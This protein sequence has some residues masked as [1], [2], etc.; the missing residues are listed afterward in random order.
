MNKQ[1]LELTWI[2]KEIRPRL[3]PRILNEDPEKS[4]Q[5]KYRVKDI[6]AK[7][8]ESAK[9]KD[10]ESDNS[11]S[12]G[13]SCSIRPFNSLCNLFNNKHI[14]NDNYLL[15][16]GLKYSKIKFDRMEVEVMSRVEIP[17]RGVLKCQ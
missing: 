7:N 6:A 3:E 13:S 2:S 5:M 16:N 10:G 17:D 1:K 11:V 9:K 14:F 15:Q 4:Y 12:R 8:A